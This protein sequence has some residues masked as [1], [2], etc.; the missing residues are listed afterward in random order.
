MTVPEDLVEQ[1]LEKAHIRFRKV[2]VPKRTGGYRT[3][4]QPSAELKLIQRWLLQNLFTYLPVSGLAT[5]FHSG[6][7]IV[8]NASSHK[9]SLYSVRVDLANFFPSIKSTDLNRIIVSSRTNLPTWTND[10]NVNTLIT[11]A[12]FDS[13][14]LLPIGYPSS[15]CIAN[16]VMY[17][18]D[19]KLLNTITTDSSRFGIATLTRYADD[20]VFSTNKRGACRSF[21]DVIK[22]LLSNTSSPKL[23][24]NETKTRYMSRPGGSTLVT[25]LRINQDGIVRVHPSYR[26]HVRLL[27]KLYSI[28][29]LTVDEHQKL[30]GH[31]AYIENADPRL[32]TRLSYRYYEDIARLR[33]I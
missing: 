12:C 31:L 8:K 27:L 25:G 29:R 6:A 5:A 26:D 14:F 10:P 16:A 9:D 11:K 22:E 3:I 2:H 7:S 32:F 17:E 20:F 15:P 13:R 24:I 28:G 30:R 21:I 4:I 18:I 19:N 33:G 23:K 1:A